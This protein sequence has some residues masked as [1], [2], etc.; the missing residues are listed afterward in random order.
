MADDRI[1]LLFA[2][3]VRAAELGPALAELQA[4]ADHITGQD[5]GAMSG[6]LF[7]LDSAP[8]ASPPPALPHNAAI[9]QQYRSGEPDGGWATYER[10]GVACLVC[11]CGTI[12]GWLPA[13]EVMATARD[14]RTELD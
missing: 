3:A 5:G 8:P 7:N 9:I 6:D 1:E 14:H 10:T 13:D 2:T 11:N 4:L 12:T